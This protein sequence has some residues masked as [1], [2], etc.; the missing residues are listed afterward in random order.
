MN[1]ATPPIID[2]TLNVIALVQSSDKRVDDL[3]N[4]H[5]RFNTDQIEHMTDMANLRAAHAKEVRQ[6][7]SDRLNAVRNVDAATGKAEADRAAAATQALAA[8]T[9]TNAETLRT[10]L[11]NTATTIA[12]QTTETVTRITERI[13]A[14]EKSSYEG[15]G[16]N[17]MSDPMISE[18][19]KEVRGLRTVQETTSGKDA[20]TSHSWVWAFGAIAA[21]G[22][23]FGIGGTF[24]SVILYL[25]KAHG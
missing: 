24:V 16:K 19:V 5:K 15:A 7:E 21:L 18:L 13:A 8:I 9:A 6:L 14:L 23:L 4:E 25:S 10:A 20:G 12:T 11:N 1:N 3:L 22:T 2:P 17:A